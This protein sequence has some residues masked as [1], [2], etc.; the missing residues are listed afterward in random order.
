MRSPSPILAAVLASALASG[1]TGCVVGTPPPEPPVLRTPPPAEG[2][3]GEVETVI[4]GDTL[5]VSGRRVRLIGIDTPELARAGRPA[6]CYAAQAL[7]R[8]TALLPRRTAVLLVADVEPI[9]RFGRALA[10]V[11]RRSDGLMVNAELVREGYAT[12]LTIPPNVRL[13]DLLVGLQRQARVA[14]RGL[15]GACGIA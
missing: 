3:P 4:D 1:V 14:G 13:A 15:W 2:V 10:Y 6:D 12:T 8:T 11:Y 7:A 5:V 9:D